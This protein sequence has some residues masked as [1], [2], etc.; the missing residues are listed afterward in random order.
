MG[1]N[2]AETR[3]RHAGSVTGGDGIGS[4]HVAFPQHQGDEASHCLP[5]IRKNNGH[6]HSDG[7]KQRPVRRV[8][9]FLFCAKPRIQFS[10]VRIQPKTVS[11]F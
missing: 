3:G 5:T 11:F 6:N 1:Q 7:S 10:G 9:G 4:E 2:A 8:R